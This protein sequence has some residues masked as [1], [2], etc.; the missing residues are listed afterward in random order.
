MIKF[1]T[2]DRNTPYLFPPTIDDW[3]AENH[4]ARFIVEIVEQLD[5]SRFRAAYRGTGSEPYDPTIMISLLFYG[6]ATGVFSSRKIEQATHD[7]VAFRYI[8]RDYHP[9]HDTI[10]SFRKQFLKEIEVCFKQILLIAHGMGQLKLG[11]ISLDGSKIKANASKHKAL[12][13]AHTK[14]LEEQISKE[15]E[16]LIEMSQVADNSKDDKTLNIVEELKRREDRLQKIA[17][18]KAEI[19]AR[20]NIRYEEEYRSYIKKIE[21]RKEKEDA[22]GKKPKGKDPKPPEAGPSDKDQVNL[23]DDESRIMPKSG[24]GFEQAYNAQ[25]TVDIDSLIIVT[26]HITKKTN[27][28]KE[29]DPT[30][31][32]INQLPASLGK[33][34]NIL[35][36]SGY[37]SESNVHKCHSQNILPYIVDKRDKH[38][39]FLAKYL[40]ELPPISNTASP[41]EQMKYRMRTELGKSLYAKRKSTIEPVFGIIKNVIGFRQFLLRGADAVS[42][43]WNLVCTAFNLKRLHKLTMLC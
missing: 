35:G 36:D 17:K 14:K 13:W 6:Y 9:D 19:E 7:S 23:T 22:T 5:V 4:L 16:Q 21:E 28:K 42:G 31:E 29:I 11:T 20:A 3:V 1:K 26:N 34:E 39:N 8:C 37:Y 38:N 25:A 24:G 41:T 27:D 43:E 33:P 18:A 12:S 32:K 15:I 10:A 40:S 30:L 2:A